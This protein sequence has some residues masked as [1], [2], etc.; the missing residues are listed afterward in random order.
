MSNVVYQND[1]VTGNPKPQTQTDGAADVNIASGSVGLDNSAPGVSNAATL[2]ANPA[3]GSSP[4]NA[5]TAIY[6]NSLLVKAGPG[7]LF[8]FSGFNS[9]GSAQWIQ[10]HDSAALP[11]EGAVPKL[12]IYAAATANFSFDAGVYGREFSNGMYMVNSSTGPTK[13]IGSAD[14]WFD[15]QYK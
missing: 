4:T 11:A 1:S 7:K 3:L 5:T 13:T 8:G 9:K 14:V 12:T 6:A 2:A 15:G 10:I